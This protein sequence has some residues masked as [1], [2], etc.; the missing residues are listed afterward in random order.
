ME[1]ADLGPH[2]DAELGVQVGERL[3][4]K[5]YFGVLDDGASQGDSLALAA[6]KVLRFAV[7]VFLK[8]EDI[9]GPVHFLFDLVRRHFHIF[10]A[11]ADIFLYRHV[12]VEGI[13]LEHHGDAAVA[14]RDFVDFLS[15]DIELAAGDLLESCHHAQG[16]G[17]AA[18]GR[19]D[20][21]DKFFLFNVK[22]EVVYGIFI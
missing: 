8:A 16:C 9:D 7:A 12:R 17:F 2:A 6:G 22:V 5:E 10:Q 11:V 3:V 18:A 20:K 1:L 19:A 4:H 13:V 21:G 14:G 15:I